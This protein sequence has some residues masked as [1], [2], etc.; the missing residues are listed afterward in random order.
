MESV[1]VSLPRRIPLTQRGIRQAFVL[2]L[3]SDH[4]PSYSCLLGVDV[5]KSVR[6][7]AWREGDANRIQ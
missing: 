6:G 7:A 3:V 5:C 4:I 2:N 1:I